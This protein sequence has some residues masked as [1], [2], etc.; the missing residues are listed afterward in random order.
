M[1]ISN[2]FEEMG[3][4][5]TAEVGKLLTRLL[6]NYLTAI[7]GKVLDIYIGTELCLNGSF[8]DVASSEEQQL[9]SSVFTLVDASG[10]AFGPLTMGKNIY[11]RGRIAGITENSY[12]VYFSNV[13]RGLDNKSLVRFPKTR[14]IEN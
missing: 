13:I 1:I 4:L 12:R 5:F 3:K 10:V 2:F 14:R 7:L 11:L 8:I 6:G 9:D